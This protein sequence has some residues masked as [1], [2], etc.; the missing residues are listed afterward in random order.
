MNDK[1]AVLVMGTWTPKTDPEIQEVREQLGRLLA[2]PHIS[3]SHRCDVLLRYIVEESLLGHTEKLKERIIGIEAFQRDAQY[4]TA[5]DPI[6]RVTAGEVRKRLAQYYYD[7]SHASELHIALPTG[8]YVP[9]FRFIGADGA[10]SAEIIAAPASPSLATHNP[11]IPAPDA[12]RTILHWKAYAL[13]L[14]LL[15]LALTGFMVAKRDA[16]NTPSEQFWGPFVSSSGSALICI[17]DQNLAGRGSDLSNLNNMDNLDNPMLYVGDV[18]TENR[19]A[20]YIQAKGKEYRV[21]N[22]S[23]TSL[24]NLRLGPVILIGAGNNVWTQRISADLPYRFVRDQGNIIQGISDST[25][26]THANWVMDFDN[27]ASYGPSDDFGI[28]ARI[29]EKSVDKIVVIIAGV[30][31]AGTEAAG[32]VLTNPE[33][34]GEI[35]KEAPKGWE[36]LNMEAV[37]A[38]HMIQGSSGPPQIVAKRFW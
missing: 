28:V 3:R 23:S 8:C 4:D 18:K 19:I 1:T 27:G 12:T 22:G 7:P 37:V 6:V 16:S 20:A 26:A 17:G 5:A 9:Q 38:V 15:I 11:G 25:S 36:N 31:G 2:S 21:Q 24:A 10:T 32:E 30:G 33:Y 29:Q 13:A 34:L 35:A 14:A